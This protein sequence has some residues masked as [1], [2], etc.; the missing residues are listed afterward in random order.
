MGPPHP[1]WPSV[2]AELSGPGH[3]LA[4]ETR[5]YS[6]SCLP[7][8]S[9]QPLASGVVVAPQYGQDTGCLGVAAARCSLWMPLRASLIWLQAVWALRYSGELNFSMRLGFVLNL[10][11]LA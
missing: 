4:H 11:S 3:G 1:R 8:Y 2:H 6:E 7:Q 5:R 9:Q 10:I